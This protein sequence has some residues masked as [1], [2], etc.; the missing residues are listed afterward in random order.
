MMPRI[1][2]LAGIRGWS[3]EDIDWLIK[4]LVGYAEYSF[5]KSHSTS[6]GMVAYRQGYMKRHTP[7][8]FWTGILTHTPTTRRSLGTSTRPRRDG[9]KIL[10]P[11]V[12]RSQITYSFE[13]DVHACRK[14]FLSVK[15]IGVVGAAELAKKGPYTSLVDLGQ[16]VLPSKVSGAKALA[17][18]KDPLDCGGIIGALAEIGAF[19]ELEE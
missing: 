11:M 13:R 9:V 5:G 15:G 10:P 16:K 8:E 7:T 3:T 1:K 2:E 14:G 19:R 12:N 6:Y 18:G 4:S 17:L